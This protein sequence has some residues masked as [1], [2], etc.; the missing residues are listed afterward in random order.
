[1]KT[2][3]IIGATGNTGKPIALGLLD[4]AQS[5][6][7]VSRDSAKAQDLVSKGARHFATSTTD[8]AGLKK[9]FNGADA[10]YI[11]L[12]GDFAAKDIAA[13]QLANVNALA[14]ALKG[15]GIKH[16][17]TL[18]SVGA[19]L[20]EGAGVVQGLQRMEE[21]FNT[22]PDI[23]FLHLRATYFLENGLNF[24]GMVKRMGIIGSPVR[25]DLKVPMVATQD[26]AAVALKHLLSLDF[27][28]KGHEYILGSR[29]Y[30]YAEIAKIYGKA[31][32][33]PELNYVQFPYDDSKKAM[34][35]MGL[36]ESY[37]DG[38]H[39]FV[40]SLNEGK[41]LEDVRRTSENTTPTTAEEFSVVFKAAYENS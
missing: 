14:E 19:H 24:A 5:V 39:Q 1:M 40:K 17:V 41:V 11:M 27:S 34:I 26:I 28:G 36:G 13:S 33:K 32:G 21:K 16:V 8:V 6:R 4:K 30:T 7:I 35:Q 3:V 31:L 20:K 25:A 12:P 23:H 15:S 29:D 18:S 22:A 38:L 9:A 2:Y 37:V 10:A